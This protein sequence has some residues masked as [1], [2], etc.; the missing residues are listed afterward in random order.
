[1]IFS[2]L[3]SCWIVEK[4]VQELHDNFTK[5]SSARRSFPLFI[6]LLNVPKVWWNKASRIALFIFHDNLSSGIDRAISPHCSW[7]KTGTGTQPFESGDMAKMLSAKLAAGV[8]RGRTA[9]RLG[10]TFQPRLCLFQYLS[11]L[12][13]YPSFDVT[14][15][16]LGGTQH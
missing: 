12:A 3:R 11:C 13:C 9:V 2:G 15:D 6:L 10:T 5:P 7:V 1:M 8:A 16:L 4:R 14:G